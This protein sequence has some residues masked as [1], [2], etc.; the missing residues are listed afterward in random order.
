M[1]T[2]SAEAKDKRPTYFQ[3]PG[4]VTQENKGENIG[5]QQKGKFF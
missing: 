2:A 5:C 3:Q 4:K 1:A